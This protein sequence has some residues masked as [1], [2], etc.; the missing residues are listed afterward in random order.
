MEHC[1]SLFDA[2]TDKEVTRAEQLWRHVFGN[3]VTVANTSALRSVMRAEH[4]MA[5]GLSLQ[6]N[7]ITSCVGGRHNMPR[8]PH[9][10]WPLTFDLE[11][12][13]RVGRGLPLCQF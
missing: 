11:S 10:S 7:L 5:S 4:I 3:Y 1:T 8:P 6:Q 2:D 9:A 13:V 12:G